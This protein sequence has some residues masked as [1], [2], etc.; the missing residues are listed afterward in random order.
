LKLWTTSNPVFTEDLELNWSLKESHVLLNDSFREGFLNHEIMDF[1]E[2][3]NLLHYSHIYA[4][5]FSEKL[6]SSIHAI[7]FMQF[8][9]VSVTVKILAPS[10]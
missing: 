1:Q 10:A 3:Q 2:L 5:F 7:F 6:Y 8:L 9:R 4:H